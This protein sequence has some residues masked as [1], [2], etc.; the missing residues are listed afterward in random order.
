MSARLGLFVVIVFGHFRPRLLLA[1]CGVRRGRPRPSAA[2]SPLCSKKLKNTMSKWYFFRA[3]IRACAAEIVDVDFVTLRPFARFSLFSTRIFR[4][5]FDS[6]S[7]F[8][9][10]GASH[11]L[12]RCG[13]RAYRLR[14]SA[15]VSLLLKLT[16]VKNNGLAALS[17]Q[18]LGRII[19]RKPLKTCRFFNIFTKK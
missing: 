13:V 17:G 19:A 16:R 9:E 8:L 3:Q 12:A 18:G 1:R 14:P 15:T 10:V 5:I 2:V 4:L 11:L 7:T 6:F